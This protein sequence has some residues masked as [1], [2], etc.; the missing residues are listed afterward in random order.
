VQWV[1]FGGERKQRFCNPVQRMEVLEKMD[2]IK[3]HAVLMP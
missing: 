3:W 1:A 2:G